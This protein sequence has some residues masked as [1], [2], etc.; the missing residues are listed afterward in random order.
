MTKDAS[1]SVKVPS[2][3]VSTVDSLAKKMGIT[4]SELV[5]K[6]IIRYIVEEEFEASENKDKESE[7]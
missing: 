2:G 6:A 5:R 3:L 4:R 7:G 1:I